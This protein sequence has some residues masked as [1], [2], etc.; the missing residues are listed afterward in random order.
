VDANNEHYHLFKTT[1]RLQVVVLTVIQLIGGL[2]MVTALYMIYKFVKQ[3]ELQFNHWQMVYHVACLLLT[4]VSVLI[5]TISMAKHFDDDE[6]Q[7][8][9]HKV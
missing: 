6:N 8:L 2:A 1:F 3:N 7:Y 4:F 5:F 9:V